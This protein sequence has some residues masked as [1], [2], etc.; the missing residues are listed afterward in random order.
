M[1]Q[2][3]GLG[4][5]ASANPP[6]GS[7]PG[8]QT[9]RHRE[10]DAEFPAEIAADAGVDG[11]LAVEKTLG[12]GEREYPLVPDVGV[13]VEALASAE[14]EGPEAVRRDVVAVGSVSLV[15]A[16]TRPRYDA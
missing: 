12:V 5:A 10:V 8:R 6:V 3:N 2:V 4:D 13:D 16:P 11:A 1:I 7:I 9:E 14:P 15:F